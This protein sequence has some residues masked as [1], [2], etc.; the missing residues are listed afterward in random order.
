V[1]ATRT[2]CADGPSTPT[3][4]TTRAA[5]ISNRRIASSI[6]ASIAASVMPG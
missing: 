3:R 6:I 5:R 4:W 2:I 1:T